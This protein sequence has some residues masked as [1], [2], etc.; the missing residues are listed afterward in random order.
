MITKS[1]EI[2]ER[3]VERIAD[4]ICVAARTAPKGRGIDNLV[5]MHIKAREKDQ[6]AEEM[7]KIAKESGAQFFARDAG[8]I[9]KA[10]VVVLFGERVKQMGV[11]PCG[12][13]GWGNCAE[14]AKHNG[15]C[16]VSIGDLGIAIG[17]AVTTAALHHVDNRVMFSAGKAALNLGLFPEDVTIAYGLPLSVSGKSIFFDRG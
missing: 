7:R 6:L 17:S 11:A 4:L 8:C 5:F 14:C 12:Y 1:Q 13:C 3:A 10:A 16:A 9:D 15:L 2:E